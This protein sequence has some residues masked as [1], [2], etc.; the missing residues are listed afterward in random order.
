VTG[1]RPALLQVS[2]D[3]TQ[4]WASNRFNGSVSVI[5]NTTG[6]VINDHRRR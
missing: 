6:I 4:L 3:G 5:N 1:A 2:P